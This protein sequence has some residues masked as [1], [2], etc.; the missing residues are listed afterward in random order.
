MNAKITITVQIDE[1]HITV[2]KLLATVVTQLEQ[3][4]IQV[5]EISKSVFK[6]E[7]LLKQLENIDFVRK[8]LT[9]LDANL[10]DCY[11][12]LSGLVK[13]KAQETDQ[14]DVEQSSK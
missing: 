8:K 5:S 2:G 7:D 1:L 11:S 13:Y 6:E 9:L 3:K 12:I 4:Q 14:K 10:E